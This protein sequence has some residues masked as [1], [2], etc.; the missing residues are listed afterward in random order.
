MNL[1]NTDMQVAVLLEALAG[2]AALAVAVTVGVCM[3][4][5]ARNHFA[6]VWDHVRRFFST[7]SRNQALQETAPP[8]DLFRHAGDGGT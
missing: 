5:C 3:V 6:L 7:D 1:F 8:P 2:L 4:M